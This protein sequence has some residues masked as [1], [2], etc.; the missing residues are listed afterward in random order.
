MTEKQVIFVLGMHRAGTSALT[1]VMALCGAALPAELLGSNDESNPTG[2][3]EPLK[4]LQLNDNC[5]HSRGSPWFDPTLRMQG[6]VIIQEDE[7]ESY[8]ESIRGFLEQ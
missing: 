3:W 4:A 2:H 1:R 6:E 8:I 5:L 7:R